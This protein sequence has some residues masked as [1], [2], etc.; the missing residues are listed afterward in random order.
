[1]SNYSKTTKL[2]DAE[3]VTFFKEN[4]YWLGKQPKLTIAA[5]GG[6]TQFEL[7]TKRQ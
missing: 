7:S 2:S 4:G 5:N 3:K 6:L 1:M